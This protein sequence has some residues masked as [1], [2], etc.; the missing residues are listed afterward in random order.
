MPTNTTDNYALLM[1]QAQDNK[2][3][4]VCT[5]VSSLHGPFTSSGIHARMVFHYWPPTDYKWDHMACTV[6]IIL[7]EYQLTSPENLDKY[8]VSNKTD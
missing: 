2:Y 4:Y 7:C 6:C 8:I 1:D 5:Y 3:R